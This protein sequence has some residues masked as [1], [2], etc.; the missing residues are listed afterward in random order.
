MPR[1]NEAHVLSAPGVC[2]GVGAS[3]AAV[4]VARR[5]FIRCPDSIEAD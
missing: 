5:T 1:D 2:R 4:H 3:R